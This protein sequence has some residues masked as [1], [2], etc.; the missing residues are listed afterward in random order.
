[1]N[2]W[3]RYLTSVEE[4]EIMAQAQIDQHKQFL[5]KLLSTSKATQTELGSEK[6]FLLE[7][8]KLVKLYYSNVY[9]E[10]VLAFC[11]SNSKSFLINKK[12]WKKFRQLI[13]LIEESFEI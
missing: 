9:K 10:N 5:P 1:M 11:I 4:E 13:P 3:K 2:F 8:N 7:N 12:T 6:V